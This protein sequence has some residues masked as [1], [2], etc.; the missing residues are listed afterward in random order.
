MKIFIGKNII[1]TGAASGMGRSLTQRLSQ[2]GAKVW[3]T[4]VNEHGLADLARA[5]PTI[6]TRILDVTDKAAFEALIQD[7]A[8]QGGLDYLFNNAGIAVFKEV[9]DNTFEE[10]QR[11][12][13]I[14]QWG[15]VYGTLAAF[16]VMRQQGSGHIVNTAS[17]AGLTPAPMLTAYAMTKHAV[18]GLSL[19]LREEAKDYGV[20]VSTV[21]PGVVETNIVQ[22]KDME[23]LPIKIDNPFEYFKRRTGFSPV[24]ADK[25]AQCILDGV[26][27]NKA[28]IIFPLHGRLIVSSFHNARKLWQL[29]QARALRMFRG[30]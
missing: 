29:G 21:C 13:D 10:W 20:N 1:V 16:E 15:V 27:R 2:L 11:T 24:S 18:V 4:D 30:Q 8:A 23:G 17:I 9:K 3:A 5:L 7:V 19:S 26:A 28:E 12:V 25:A 14:N 22:S 6:Q